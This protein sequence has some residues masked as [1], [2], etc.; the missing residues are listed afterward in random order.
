M[1]N[2]KGLTQNFDI[3]K[4]PKSLLLTPGP[5]QGYDTAEFHIKGIAIKV[6]RFK[7]EKNLT[8]G[9]RDISNQ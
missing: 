4:M 1:S 8:C 6:S 9:Y 7:Y 3:M 2:Q 5:T